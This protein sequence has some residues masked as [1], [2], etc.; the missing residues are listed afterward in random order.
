M[1]EVLKIHTKVFN[2]LQRNERVAARQGTNLLY[3]LTHA[4]Q[5]GRDPGVASGE[6]KLIAYVGHDTNIANVAALLN[7]HW[8]L[9]EYP[10]DDMPPGG[11]LIFEVRQPP[12]KPEAPENQRVYAFFA[13]QSADTM[14][15]LDKKAPTI[16]P[17][18]IPCPGG[19]GSCSVSEFRQLA[20]KA[21]DANNDCITDWPPAAP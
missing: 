8:E 18:Y 14:R 19:A 7:L 12:D 20:A 1:L 16:V 13:A 5:Y 2:K 4:I 21:I 10:R 9:P 15:E 11:A 6:N 17:V 3:H